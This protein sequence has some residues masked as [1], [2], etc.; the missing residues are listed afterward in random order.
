LSKQADYLTPTARYAI[1]RSTLEV[2]LTVD[3]PTPSIP[4]RERVVVL[5]GV[6]DALRIGDDRLQVPD[7]PLTLEC[8]L[9]ADGFGERTGLVAKTESSEYGLF[10]GMGVPGFYIFLGDRYVEL[11]ASEPLLETDRW[12]HVAG[13]YD[14][15]ESRLY[16]DGRLVRSEQRSGPRR[17]N[18]LPLYVGGDVDGRGRLVSP[19][20]G[21]IDAV[22]LSTVARYTGTSFEPVRRPEADQHDALLLNMDAELGPW[23]YDASSRSAHPVRVGGAHLADADG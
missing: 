8:W 3:F 11:Q 12:H 7:G 9:R 15:S 20:Y 13:V 18:A 17:R 10:V 5:D 21:S 14:G 6:D 19:F 2:P 1:P 22:R 23:V 4:A 16:V